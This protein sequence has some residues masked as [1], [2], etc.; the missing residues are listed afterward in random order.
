MG[1]NQP[2]LKRVCE[3]LGDGELSW[4]LL[5]RVKLVWRKE[6]ETAGGLGAGMG[7]AGGSVG[8]RGERPKAPMG[9]SQVSSNPWGKG[10][11]PGGTL[12]AEL[13]GRKGTW[14]LQTR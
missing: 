9:C 11:L 8:L 2:D 6:A 7:V 3:T 12:Q 13:Q 14:D 4:L 10:P 5:G 1:K